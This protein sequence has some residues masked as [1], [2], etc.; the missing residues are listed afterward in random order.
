LHCRPTVLFCITLRY[1]T[2]Y[3]TI[4]QHICNINSD[5]NEEDTAVPPPAKKMQREAVV[6]AQ[7][8]I[9]IKEELAR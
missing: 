7:S 1:I 8:T 9:D 5:G 6:R 4:L 2:L 3:Y